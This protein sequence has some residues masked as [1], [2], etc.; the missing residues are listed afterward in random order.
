MGNQISYKNEVT[1]AEKSDGILFKNTQLTKVTEPL[2]QG[3]NTENCSNFKTTNYYITAGKTLETADAEDFKCVETKYEGKNVVAC[4]LKEGPFYDSIESILEDT[5]YTENNRKAATQACSTGL[6][7]KNRLPYI[8]SIPTANDE[9]NDAN[10]KKM[11]G[12]R[13][14]E[15]IRS[16]RGDYG[17]GGTEE[18]KIVNVGNDQNKC[19]MLNDIA[20]CRS[21]YAEKLYGPTGDIYMSMQ[22]GKINKDRANAKQQNNIA[23]AKI[24]A[25]NNALNFNTCMMN[26][27]L[28]VDSSGNQKYLVQAFEVLDEED[29][30]AC[31]LGPTNLI[32]TNWKNIGPGKTFRNE[33][34][35]CQTGKCWIHGT[36]LLIEEQKKRTEYTSSEDEKKNI[37]M[38]Y[39]YY[40]DGNETPN[41]CSKCNRKS[42]G[43][44]PD[45]VAATRAKN[46]Q[47]VENSKNASEG[48]LSDAELMLLEA[49]QSEDH[50]KLLAQINELKKL[51]SQKNSQ[52]QP[53]TTTTTIVSPAPAN[54][55]VKL[56]KKH[57][58][59][60]F[61][62]TGIFLLLIIILLIV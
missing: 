58:M 28:T 47:L 40:W 48:G 20:P 31:E 22:M 42:V 27:L 15:V 26:K 5:A 52:S 36:D 50:L 59:I 37:T 61:I 34:M 60:I 7:W 32:G 45:L 17:N 23:N 38:V 12:I 4:K 13:L 33:D 1:S 18:M 29:I 24:I 25:S 19:N 49:K 30:K 46:R 8:G 9:P 44:D 55:L 6:V 51:N 10:V 54:E 14:K 11:L 3:G 53:Q 2:C 21:N 56:F 43:Y 62:G 57:K 16:V 39:P 41:F 35:F